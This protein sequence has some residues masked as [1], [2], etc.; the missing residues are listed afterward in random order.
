M[1]VGNGISL[2]PAGVP[3]PAV[4][5]V[6]MDTRAGNFY[7][8]DTAADTDEAAGTVKRRPTSADFQRQRLHAVAGIGAPQ[9]FF[10][11]LSALGLRFTAHTFPDHHRYRQADLQLV[12]DAIVTTEKDAVK[13][14]RLKLAL[15]VWVVPLEISV[16]PDLTSLIVEKLNGSASS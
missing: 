11:L 5:F 2:L 10:N 1:V 13:L 12:G 16:E 6:R 3:A 14:Q 9:R 4:P 7:R 8:A 15:P